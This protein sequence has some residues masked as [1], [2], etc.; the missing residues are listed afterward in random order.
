M[1]RFLRALLP[2]KDDIAPLSPIQQARQDLLDDINR[3]RP[4]VR[5]WSQNRARQLTGER[6]KR[7]EG[8]MGL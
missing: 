8:A 2:T 1:I 7:F 6:R 4:T 3:R 5:Q